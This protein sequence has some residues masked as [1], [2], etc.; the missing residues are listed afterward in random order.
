MKD[1]QPGGLRAEVL[2]AALLVLAGIGG[3]LVHWRLSNRNGCLM[4]LRNVQQAARSHQGVNG[5][6]LGAP[7]KPSDLIPAYLAPPRCPAGGTYTWSPVHPPIGTTVI[8]CSHPGHQPDP[9]TVAG[10]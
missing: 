1:G 6:W 2:I 8:R 5:L 10:W 9:A 4:N 3:F 7:L